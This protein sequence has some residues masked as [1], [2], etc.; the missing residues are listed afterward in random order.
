MNFFKLKIMEEQKI[1]EQLKKDI[2][3]TLDLKG[4][5]PKDIVDDEP[6]FGDEGIGLDSIDA[7]DLVSLLENKYDIVIEDMVVGKKIISNIET[8]VKYII[9]SQNPK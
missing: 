2:I 5:T 1:K 9:K 3:E 8:M 6:L 7:L 4:F